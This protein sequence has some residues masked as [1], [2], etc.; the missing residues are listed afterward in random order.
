MLPDSPP[1]INDGHFQL[2][3]QYLAAPKSVDE[4]IQKLRY[5]DYSLLSRTAR[6]KAARDN[7]TLVAVDGRVEMGPKVM[8][9]EGDIS[10][11]DWLTAAE[12]VEEKTLKYHGTAR[13]DPLKAHHRNVLEI[14]RSYDWGP[15][16]IY[17]KKTRELMASDPR[18]D[19]SFVNQNLVARANMAYKM[20]KIRA[21]LLT[22]QWQFLRPSTSYPSSASL[23]NTIHP[24]PAPSPP[25]IAS[26]YS[27]AS[28]A[29]RTI[30]WLFLDPVNTKFVAHAIELS[31]YDWLY[32]RTETFMQ[33]KLVSEMQEWFD[34]HPKL[35]TLELWIVSSLIPILLSALYAKL[36]LTSLIN[37]SHC[38]TSPPNGLQRTQRT[39][40]P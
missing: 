40:I 36:L 12:T 10:H 32:M 35:S 19:P 16:Y 29:T 6:E 13:S 23:P 7:E 22:Q 21:N 11:S 26:P 31:G 24:F 4:A 34:F 1:A 20:E 8:I 17:D 18:H 27:A 9:P 38:K 28:M 39:S 5:V 30:V 25:S 37:P 2:L 14:F 33:Q 3:T 15:A